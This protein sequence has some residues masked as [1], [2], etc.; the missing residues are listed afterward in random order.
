MSSNI[1]EKFL[2]FL[3]LSVVGFVLVLGYCDPSSRPAVL[4]FAKVALGG[5]LTAI[6]TNAIPRPR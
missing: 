5:L 6:T 1:L 4:D 2:C 3:L